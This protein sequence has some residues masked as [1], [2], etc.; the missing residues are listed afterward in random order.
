MRDKCHS[1]Y[2]LSNDKRKNVGGLIDEPSF[3]VRILK[4]SNLDTIRLSVN[5]L[6]GEIPDLKYEPGIPKW[7]AEEVHANDTL[8]DVLIGLPKV[9]PDANFFAI[10]FNRLT[11]ELP[12][13][14]LYHPKLDVWIPYSLI[15]S[16]EGKTS[17]G[18]N[19]GFTNEPVSL[20]YYYEHYVNKKY[21]PNNTQE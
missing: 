11:G 12:D 9:L 5:Y 6:H 21:N 4:W 19:A 18:Q 3:P 17:D 15:F 13:W 8:P 10:N 2:D 1:I 16:Q 20:D 7:T 14:L